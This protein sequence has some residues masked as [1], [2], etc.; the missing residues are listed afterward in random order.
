MTQSVQNSTIASINSV[1]ILCTVSK[2]W[3]G[4]R[5]VLLSSCGVAIVTR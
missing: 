4:M 3:G 2:Y 5:A 1:L